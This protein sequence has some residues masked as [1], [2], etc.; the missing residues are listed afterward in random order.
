MSFKLPNE[1]HHLFEKLT[2]QPQSLKH[3]W[4]VIFFILEVYNGSA[5]FHFQANWYCFKQDSSQQDSLL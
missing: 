5:I 2:R 3:A 4:I 1:P